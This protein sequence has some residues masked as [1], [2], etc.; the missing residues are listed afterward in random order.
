MQITVERERRTIDS[1]VGFSLLV[2]TDRAPVDIGSVLSVLVRDGKG[3]FR[4]S[5]V[6]GKDLVPL[7]IIGYPNK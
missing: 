4:C 1:K 6:R 2:K 7:I 3:L 5:V